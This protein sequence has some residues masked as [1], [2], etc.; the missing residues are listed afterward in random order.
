MALI[1]S[2]RRSLLLL[3][4]AAVAGCSNGGD[5]DAAA[6]TQGGN[7]AR[8]REL[9]R[10]YGC[11]AC[12]TIPHVTGAVAVVGPSLDGIASR[13][14]IAG[15]LPNEPVNMMRWIMNPPGID[16]KTAMPNLR[17]SARDARDIAAYLYTLR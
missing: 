13:A 3:G 14:Y 1:D 17:V 15:V 5:A 16:P 11:G 2:F 7:A 9:V 8:G 12:H 4:V 6:L 10:S